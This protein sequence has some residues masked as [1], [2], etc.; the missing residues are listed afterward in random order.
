MSNKLRNVLMSVV[1]G[2]WAINFVAPVFVKGYVP[3]NEVH[4]VF[5]A[6]VSGL[7]LTYRR[8]D[9]RTGKVKKRDGVKL[10]Y[11][12]QVLDGQQAARL[13]TED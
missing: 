5:M 8:D 10:D 12:E 7:L 9:E 2:V 13:G 6:I 4:L 3:P 1:T 11:Q